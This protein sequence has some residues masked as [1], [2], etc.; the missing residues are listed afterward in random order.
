[1]FVAVVEPE[2]LGRHESIRRPAP[3]ELRDGRARRSPPGLRASNVTHPLGAVTQQG[4][5]R[6][7]GRDVPV[8]AAGGRRLDGGIDPRT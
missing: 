7:G 1:M 2:R 4:I 3:A 8:R 5:H 6:R